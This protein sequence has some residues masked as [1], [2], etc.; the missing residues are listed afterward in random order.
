MCFLTLNLQQRAA[1]I[2][3]EVE[4]CEG[5]GLGP[6]WHPRWYIK[7]SFRTYF[8]HKNIKHKSLL[9][10]ILKFAYDLSRWYIFAMDV[11][12]FINRQNNNYYNLLVEW[13][14]MK[15]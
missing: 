9:K 13:K 5:V 8:N 11:L 1:S 4:T 3:Y 7:N 15:P 6:S 12:R 2:L 10:T 14:Q